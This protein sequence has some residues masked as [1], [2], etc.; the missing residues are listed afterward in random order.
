MAKRRIS[1]FDATLRD[2]EQAPGNAMSPQQKVELALKMEALGVDTIEAGFPGSSPA[3]VLATQL[4]AS[5]LTTARFATFNRANVDD[6]RMSME[7]AGERSNHQIQI[8]G[9]GSDLHLRH[10]RSISRAEAVKEV[11]DAVRFAAALGAEDISFGVEDAS[12][13]EYDFIHELVDT[14]LAGGARTIILADTTGC[15]TPQE[16]GDLCAAVRSWIPSDVVLSTR[17]HDD[18]GLSLANAIA[19]IQAGADEVQVTLTGVGERSG[20][21]PLEEMAAVLS[22]KGDRFGATTSL[23]TEGLYDAYCLLANTISLPEAR[24]KAA[25]GR[26]A[27]A[28]QAGIH[29]AAILRDPRT[30]EY[31]NPELFGRERQLLIGRHSGRAAVRHVLAEAGITADT[32][33]VDKLYEHIANREG[34]EADTLDAWR[35][36]ALRVLAAEAP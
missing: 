8:C 10:K 14:A 6:V 3:D 25:F 36:H 5:K 12:R 17:C 29:Q 9:T 15:G 23:R 16:Y 18:L 24:N 1:F 2:G 4:I 13:G 26:N 28:T 22:Y 34:R 20:N 32:A 27:F 19:G 21:T 30:Y 31:V 33:M 7:A 35:A 11:D